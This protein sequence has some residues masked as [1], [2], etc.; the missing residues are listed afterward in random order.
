MLVLTDFSIF[1]TWFYF[2]KVKLRN[3]WYDYKD[4]PR[5]LSRSRDKFIGCTIEESCFDSWL[6]SYLLWTTQ[7][8]GDKSPSEASVHILVHTES[9]PKIREYSLPL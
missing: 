6:G 7:N 4:E 3:V 2:W 1:F 9:H 5:K 8:I